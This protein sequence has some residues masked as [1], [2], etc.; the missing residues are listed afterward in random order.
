MGIVSQGAEWLSGQS[1]GPWEAQR[2]AQGLKA[3]DGPRDRELRAL[4]VRGRIP[5]RHTGLPASAE[6]LMRVSPAGALA[7]PRRS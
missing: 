2:R 5:Q 6:A 1:Q 4:P 3:H 7:N